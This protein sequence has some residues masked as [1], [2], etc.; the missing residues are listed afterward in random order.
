MTSAPNLPIP[1]MQRTRDYYRAICYDTP[2][3]APSVSM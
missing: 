3:L 2:Q 1:Y